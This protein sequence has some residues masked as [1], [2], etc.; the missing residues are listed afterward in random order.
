MKLTE[1]DLSAQTDVRVHLDVWLKRYEWDEILENQ[2]IIERLKNRIRFNE[3]R[4][5]RLGNV[6]NYLSTCSRVKETT[7][8]LQSILT[9][10]NE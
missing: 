4:M 7:N 5:S 1:D 9:G 3:R 8:E 6:T 10:D 2:E